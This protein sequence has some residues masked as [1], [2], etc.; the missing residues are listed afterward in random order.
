MTASK[1]RL[2]NVPLLCYPLDYPD[3][4]QALSGAE[5]V[6]ASVDVLKVGLELFV[7]AG[8]EIVRGVQRLSK[9]VF[10][11]LKLHDIPETVHRAVARACDL[12]V[13]YLT[14]HTGGGPRMIAAAVDA[15]SKRSSALQL[16]GV[17]VLTSLDAGELRALDVSRPPA[18]YALHL[19]RL[20]FGAGLTGFVCSPQEVSEL[21][22]ALGPSAVLVTPGVRP[23]GTDAGD[24]KRIATPAQ[25]V[26]AGSSMLVVGRPIRDAADPSVAAAAIRSEMREAASA[27]TKQ[28]FS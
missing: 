11:D 10:L 23:L 3:A 12:G 6:G 27:P 20:G 18:D 22:A 7:E 1:A 2:V 25:A 16:L 5:R 21:R 8:P 28:G 19:A 13:D 26:R 15:V 9:P 14:I 24:Q 4:S 17:T